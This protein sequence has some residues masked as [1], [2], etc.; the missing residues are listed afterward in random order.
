MNREKKAHTHTHVQNKNNTQR[1]ERACKTMEIDRMDRW[2]RER[3][4]HPEKQ[5]D[6]IWE[7]ENKKGAKWMASSKS[8]ITAATTKTNQTQN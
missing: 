6:G 2:E 3:S 7:R 4:R 5:R 1:W 8:I